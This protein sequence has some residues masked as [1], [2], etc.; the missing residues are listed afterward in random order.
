MNPYKIVQPYRKYF[1]KSKAFL[2]PALGI[3]RDAPIVPTQTYISYG[4]RIHPQDCKLLV[5]YESTKYPF[6]MFSKKKL[7][8]HPMFVSSFRWEKGGVVYIF[9]FENMMEDWDY[10]LQGRYSQLSPGLKQS[11][12]NYFGPTSNEYAYMDSFLF[13]EKYYDTYAE[14]FGLDVEALR[15]GAELTDAFDRIKED[16]L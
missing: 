2:Y 5:Y 16:L 6:Y 3:R 4:D 8:S 13:P 1:Q 14:L 9:D 7:W 10:F 15:E 12:R 11:I